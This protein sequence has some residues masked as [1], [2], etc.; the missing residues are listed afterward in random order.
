MSLLIVNA[1]PGESEAAPRAIQVL[2]PDKVLET[3]RMRLLPCMGCNHCWLKTPGVCA[4]QDDYQEILK[5]YLS[6]DA[7]IFLAG[8]ALGFVDH[9]M[10]NLA[11]RILPLAT[12]YIHMVD[13]QARHVPRYHKEYRFGLLYQGEAD[14]A[15]LDRW[16][17]RTALNMGGVSL[18]TFPLEEAKEV[19]SCI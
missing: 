9:D 4:I 7:T 8:T 14:R 13:G 10:K 5:G 16:L 12:M 15:Y 2:A 6:Y 17:A 1:L 11:D 19:L 3:R 18:G